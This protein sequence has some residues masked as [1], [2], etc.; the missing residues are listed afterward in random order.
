MVSLQNVSMEW[1]GPQFAEAGAVPGSMPKLDSHFI[2]H[3]Y[4]VA[5]SFHTVLQGLGK[6]QLDWGRLSWIGEDTVG[7]DGTTFL[8]LPLCL[9]FSLLQPDNVIPQLDFSALV[10]MF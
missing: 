8:L 4:V 3:P 9:F 10:N 5:V 6:A 1:L 7:R 2:C